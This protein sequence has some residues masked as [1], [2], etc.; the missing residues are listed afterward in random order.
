MPVIA[1]FTVTDSCCVGFCRNHNF[2]DAAHIIMLGMPAC[3][4]H[5]LISGRWLLEKPYCGVS[6]I[7]GS[8]LRLALVSSPASLGRFAFA[9]AFVCVFVVD[10]AAAAA[11][12][13]EQGEH[14]TPCV[15]VLVALPHTRTRT[16]LFDANG[17]SDGH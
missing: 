4:M 16:V 9:F 5:L 13:A 11:N 3:S 17:P 8:L 6:F 1:A 15:S 12:A 10:W 7:F 2:R 14:Y